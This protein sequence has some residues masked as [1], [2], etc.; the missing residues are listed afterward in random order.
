MLNYSNYEN[1][2]VD[3]ETL[4]DNQNSVIFSIG[5]VRFDILTG[6]HKKESEIRIKIQDAIN[7][8]FD[9][10]EDTIDFWLLQ[11]PE[12]RKKE[13]LRKGDEISLKKALIMFSQWLWG[14]LNPSVN[15][16]ESK[17][18]NTIIWSKGPRFDLGILS[19]AYT[20]YGMKVPWNFRNERCVRTMLDNLDENTKIKTKDKYV[21]HNSLQ[22]AKLQAD[23][24]SITYND[25]IQEHKIKKD[26]SDE[27]SLGVLNKDS[28]QEKHER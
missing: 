8:G 22:D 17:M 7:N 16:V 10:T 19:N 23:L 15:E 20:K 27:Y 25:M 2:M 3:I 11:L 14:E 24:V 6:E 1:V 4:G 18:E 13:L 28:I 26:I 5:A 12:K 21:G 9:V